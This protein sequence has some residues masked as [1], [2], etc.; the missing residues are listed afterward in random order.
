[1]RWIGIFTLGGL[2][3]IIL[4]FLRRSRFVP[5]VPERLLDTR[6]GDDE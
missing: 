5:L 6:P 3:A 1:M 2:M 4:E